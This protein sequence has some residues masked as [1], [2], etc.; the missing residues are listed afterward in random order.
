[1][2]VVNYDGSITTS[3]PG[4]MRFHILVISALSMADHLVGLPRFHRSILQGH[5]FP[6][7]YA[8]GCLPHSPR[9]E[10]ASVLYTGRGDLLD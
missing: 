7:Q 5:R 1:M 2:G 10:F 9:R 6:V 3:L 4:Q 8:A